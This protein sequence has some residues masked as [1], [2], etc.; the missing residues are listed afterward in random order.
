MPRTLP[1]LSDPLLLLE[2]FLP[3]LLFHVLDCVQS[4]DQG[5]HLALLVALQ[6]LW[7]L[8][9]LRP[10]YLL[11]LAL[12]HFLY[13]FEGQLRFELLRDGEGQESLRS[14]IDGL[15]LRILLQF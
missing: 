3:L 6:Q 13:G 11:L 7:H 8:L 10:P 1:R 2:L 12:L 14:S 5:C 4:L 9:A 15:I